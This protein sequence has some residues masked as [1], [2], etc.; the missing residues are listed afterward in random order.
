MANFVNNRFSLYLS[1]LLNFYNDEENSYL[2]LSI[3]RLFYEQPLEVN[4]GTS[5]DLFEYAT[6]LPALMQMRAYI[7]DKCD[8]IY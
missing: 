6:F 8:N 7:I 2:L 1:E 4:P 3:Y 5:T